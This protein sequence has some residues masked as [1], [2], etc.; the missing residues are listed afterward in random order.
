MGIREYAV[1]TCVEFDSSFMN[2]CLFCKIINKEIKAEIIYE[3]ENVL[4]FLDIMP[5]APGHTMVIPKTHT[6]NLVGLL[7]EKIGLFFKAVKKVISILENGL[8]PDGFTLGINQ[9]KASG[10]EVQHLHFHIIPRWLDDNGYPIQKVVNN[11]PQK[12]LEEIAKKI[13]AASLSS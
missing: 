2:G 11:P 4:A 5:R 8:K 12:S 6:A 3:D 7:N 9:G 10:Q 1:E 13:R